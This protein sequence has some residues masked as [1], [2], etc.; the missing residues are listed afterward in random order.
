LWWICLVS[1][2][3]GWFDSTLLRCGSFSC[4][5]WMSL[6][7]KWWFGPSYPFI[8][9]REHIQVVNDIHLSVL[10]CYFEIYLAWTWNMNGSFLTCFSAPEWCRSAQEAQSFRILKQIKDNYFLLFFLVL[11][12]CVVTLSVSFFY[13]CFRLICHR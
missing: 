5:F 6:L 4:E 10:F 11:F 7:G 12:L 13:N 9:S 8:G 1:W 3:L 2:L